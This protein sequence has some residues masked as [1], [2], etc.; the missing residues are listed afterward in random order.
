MLHS[1]G[2]EL[3]S[4]KGDTAEEVPFVSGADHPDRRRSSAVDILGEQAAQNAQSCKKTMALPELL[5][6]SAVLGHSE[7]GPAQARGK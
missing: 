6:K 5:Q 4:S 3:S 7:S 1:N 2:E